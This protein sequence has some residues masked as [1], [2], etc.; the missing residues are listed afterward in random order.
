MLDM[1]SIYSVSET[2]REGDTLY[3]SGERWTGETLKGVPT[4]PGRLELPDGS[5]FDGCFSGKSV[6]E[7]EFRH[8]MGTSMKGYWL[9]GKMLRGAVEFEDGDRLEGEWRND[10]GLWVLSEGKFQTAEGTQTLTNESRIE[11]NGK[12]LEMRLPK[13]GFAIVYSDLS[14]PNFPEVKSLTLSPSGHYSYTKHELGNVT[15]YSH[16]PHT[17]FKC[18]KVER[19]D[20]MGKKTAVVVTPLGFAVRETG[21]GNCV[22]TFKDFEAVL[23]RGHCEMASGKFKVKGEMFEVRGGKE[24]SLGHLRVKKRAE[25]ELKVKFE[26]KEFDGMHALVAS[27]LKMKVRPSLMF[28]SKPV[29][30]SKTSVLTDM[31]KDIKTENQCHIF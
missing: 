20:P 2:T 8:F 13:I 31:V 22:C 19:M 6:F 1:L 9:N 4:G 30:S 18:E 7:G 26:G 14:L 10:A 23:L 28:R 25:T 24:V 16:Y 15:V 29:K 12:K 27:L 11:S 21:N 3:F 17:L 5:F